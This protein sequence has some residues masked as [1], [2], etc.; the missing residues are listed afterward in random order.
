MIHH[1]FSLWSLHK[2]IR[3]KGFIQYK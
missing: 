3:N 2:T 1:I